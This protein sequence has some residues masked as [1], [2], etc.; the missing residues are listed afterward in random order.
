MDVAELMGKI[1]LDFELYLIHGS[2]F[3]MKYRY[4]YEKQNDETSI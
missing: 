2:Q 1:K 3:W 4:N